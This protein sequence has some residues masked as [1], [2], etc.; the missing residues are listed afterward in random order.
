VGLGFD[1]PQST[2]TE[3]ERPFVFESGFRV[4]GPT[5]AT[6]VTYRPSTGDIPQSRMAETVSSSGTVTTRTTNTPSTTENL[7]AMSVSPVLQTRPCQACSGTGILP[8]HSMA[9]QGGNSRA[10]VDELT[11]LQQQIALM[12]RQVAIMQQRR[13][14]GCG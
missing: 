11:L 5:T 7:S 8:T 14:G 6:P 4:I 3:S 13:A 2:A 9:D 12:S 10:D 1:L